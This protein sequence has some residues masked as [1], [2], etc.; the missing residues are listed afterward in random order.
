MSLGLR[1]KT[2][3]KAKGLTQQKLAEMVGVSRTYIQALEG[4]KRTPSMKLLRNLAHTLDVELSDL[5]FHPPIIAT[6]RLYLEEILDY[7]DEFEI[8][9]KNTK[10]T[11]RETEFIKQ[12]IDLVL[13][14]IQKDRG[15][16]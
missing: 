2:I 13:N 4:N 5:L 15:S 6:R 10:L 12:M 1:I 14:Y 3:R 7:N 9:Y 11:K 16:N 8:W